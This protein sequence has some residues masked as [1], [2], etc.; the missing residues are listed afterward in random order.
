[1]VESCKKLDYPLLRQKGSRLFTDHRNLVYIFNPEG[2]NPSMAR[3][4]SA[5][6][7]RWSMALKP[8]HFVIEHISVVKMFR[9]IY[10]LV[11]KE[12]RRTYRPELE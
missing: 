4:Q 7:Q 3:C 2:Y 9:V 10:F 12:K 5:K 11:R 8:Y 1:M 6:L